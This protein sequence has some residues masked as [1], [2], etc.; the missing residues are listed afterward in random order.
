MIVM[1]MVVAAAACYQHAAAAVL[2]VGGAG[3]HSVG[4]SNG[5]RGLSQI[6]TVFIAVVKP[7]KSSS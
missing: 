5:K 2:F 3:S 6:A 1:L 7:I 4:G